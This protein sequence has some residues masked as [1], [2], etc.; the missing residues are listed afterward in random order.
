MYYQI[1]PHILQTKKNKAIYKVYKE[2]PKQH[3]KL[4]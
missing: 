2:Q 4:K 1:P 3:S